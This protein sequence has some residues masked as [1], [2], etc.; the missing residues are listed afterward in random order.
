LAKYLT[1][2]GAAKGLVAEITSELQRDQL[3]EAGPSVEEALTREFEATKENVLLH[4][5]FTALRFYL[6]DLFRDITHEWP[7][8]V[9]GATNYS[10]LVRSVEKWRSEANGHVLWVTFNYDGLLD[11]ALADFY[12]HSFAEPGVPDPKLQAFLD[13]SDWALIKLHGSHDWRRRTRLVLPANLG[14][15]NAEATYAFLEREWDASQDLPTHG[16]EYERALSGSW[17]SDADDQRRLWA[18][19]LMAPLASK[20]TFE[21][22]PGHVDYLE[23]MLPEVDLILTIG[24]RGQEAHFLQKLATM[25]LNPPDV[26]SVTRST[27]TS[28]AVAE[29]VRA[30]CGPHALEDQNSNGNPSEG[31]SGL[32]ADTDIARQLAERVASAR[33]RRESRDRTIRAALDTGDQ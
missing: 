26:L 5:G 13:H 3:T 23:T 29:R 16:T 31:F 1:G 22:P 24:W 9:G 15:G 33:E 12:D 10:W 8:Q 17:P 2:R 20:S 30:A 21:C 14:T 11:Q 32:R 6:R 28:M 25:R 18:P 27:A 19:A 7:R 4:R